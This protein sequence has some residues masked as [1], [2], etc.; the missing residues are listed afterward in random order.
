MKAFHP[1]YYF[2][3]AISTY[4]GLE[5]PRGPI[6]TARKCEETAYLSPSLKITFCTMLPVSLS[7]S[8]LS[9]LSLPSHLHRAFHLLATHFHLLLLLLLLIVKSNQLRTINRCVAQDP[10]VVT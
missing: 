2:L 3:M 9:Q 4:L 5:Q 1:A 7:L 6:S 8:P 10:E